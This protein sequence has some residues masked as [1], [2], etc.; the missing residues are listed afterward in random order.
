LNRAGKTEQ[1]SKEIS[2][3]IQKLGYCTIEAHKLFVHRTLT[4]EVMVYQKE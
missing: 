2:G 1:L 3:H 4:R